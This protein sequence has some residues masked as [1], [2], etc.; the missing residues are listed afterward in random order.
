[1]DDDE[2]RSP[3]PGTIVI[4]EDLSNLSVGELAERVVALKEEIVRLENE[5]QKKQTH[6]AAA[7]ALFKS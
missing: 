3:K 1:M 7:A 5:K 2:P 6:E 4:G